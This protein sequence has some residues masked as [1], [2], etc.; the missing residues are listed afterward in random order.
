MRFTLSIDGLVRG[1]QL[2]DEI[3]RGT[4]VDLTDRYVFYQPDTIQ[5]P[6]ALVAGR[7]TEIQAIVDV[8]IPDPLY[9]PADRERFVAEQAGGKAQEIP[10]WATWTEDEALAWYSEHVD[11]LIGAI[12]D[13]DKLTAVQF[14]DNAQAISAQFQ[15][16][17][18]AQAL[19][20]RNL[21]RMVIALR[22]KTWP[23]LEGS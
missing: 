16:I 2:V 20:I 19:V 8:H 3:L 5:V 22:N 7:E 4:G 18:A 9:F 11:T 15:D 6:D 12:P 13:I 14:R 17:I 21:A 23:G 1:D 10:G